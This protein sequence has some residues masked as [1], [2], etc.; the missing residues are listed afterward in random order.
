MKKEK[1]ISLIPIFRGILFILGILFSNVILSQVLDIKKSFDI[2]K[3][4]KKS[5]LLDVQF[6]KTNSMYNLYYVSKLNKKIAK[7]EIYSF[8]KDFNFLKLT[9]D[10]LE[11][12]QG[13][14]KYKWWKFKGEEYTYEGVTIDDKDDLTARKILYE[15]KYSWFWDGYKV[16]KKVLNKEKIKDDQGEPYFHIMYYIDDNEGIAYELCGSYNDKEKYNEFKEMNLLKIDKNLKV[17]TKTPLKFDY[18]QHLV[19]MIYNLDANDNLESLCYI[20]APKDA[21][22]RS[23]PDNKNY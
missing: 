19:I 21:G 9:K 11:F 2:S 12:E 7:F 15:M 13:R 1:Q 8:D 20:F 4:T 23:D 10:S 16:N 18:P 6:D 22:K 5:A 17:I 3:K 14:N